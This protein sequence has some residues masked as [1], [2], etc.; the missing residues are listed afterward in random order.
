MDCV[1]A[2]VGLRSRTLRDGIHGGGLVGVS[3]AVWA[4]FLVWTPGETV[5]SGWERLVMSLCAG[6]TARRTRWSC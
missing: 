6:Q 1:C 4:N 5:W 2:C 3:P